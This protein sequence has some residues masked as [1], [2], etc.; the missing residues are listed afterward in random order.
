[1]GDAGTLAELV[2]GIT[3]DAAAAVMAWAVGGAAAG[4]GGGGST[5]V[6]VDSPD[7]VYCIHCRTK[8]P[9][10]YNSGDLCV[11]CGKQAEPILSCYWC[12]AS[13]P[14]KFCRQCGAEFVATSELD[15][16]IHLKREGLSKDE[17]PKKLMGMSAAEKDALWGRIRK[18]RG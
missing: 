18:S 1:M 14:G 10:D 3:K 8:Q 12:S 13:G 2:A 9:K 6:T 15:L 4:A 17:V 11:S 16:A 7:A 5:S